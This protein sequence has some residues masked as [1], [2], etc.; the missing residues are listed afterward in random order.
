MHRPGNRQEHRKRHNHAPSQYTDNSALHVVAAKQKRT[1]PKTEPKKTC[2]T[3]TSAPPAGHP[4]VS[5][6]KTT[7]KIMCGYDRRE[8]C[9]PT[10]APDVSVTFHPPSSHGRG[11]SLYRPP[12]P[13][14][15]C[16]E[17]AGVGKRGRT[18]AR[19]MPFRSSRGGREARSAKVCSNAVPGPAIE[20]KDG[21]G[22]TLVVVPVLMRSPRQEGRGGGRTSSRWIFR[23]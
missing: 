17:Q 16:C 13:T 8:A 14:I 11:F 21:R 10:P 2:T 23:R 3:I 7:C 12:A 9:S 19:P 20:I 18:S 5:L 4:K 15:P 1:N 6:W 22:R